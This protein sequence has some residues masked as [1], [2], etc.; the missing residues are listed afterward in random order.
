MQVY[1]SVLFLFVC[2]FFCK[3]LQIILTKDIPESYRLYLM[4]LARARLYAFN[5]L[6][7]REVFSYVW[8]AL[9][10]V[11]FLMKQTYSVCPGLK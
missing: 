4:L 3:E 11:I 9:F 7:I 1:R 10:W 5:L 8:N 2:L 6:G